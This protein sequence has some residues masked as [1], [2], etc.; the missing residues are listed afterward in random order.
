MNPQAPAVTPVPG[1][2]EAARRLSALFGTVEGRAQEIASRLRSIESG[3]GP[4][5]WAGQAADGFS[6]LL[7]ETG[8]DLTTLAASYGKASQA[9]ATYATEL[10]AAQDAARAAQAEATTAT[11]A[12]DR[13]STDQT[14]ARSDADRHAVEAADAQARMD[15]VGA[16]AAEQRRTDAVGRENAARGAADQAEQALRAAQQ[17]ADE[18]AGR[19]D[20]AAAKCIRELQD[21]SRAGIETRNI[22]QPVAAGGPLQIMTIATTLDPSTAAADA[23]LLR[24][25]V[26]DPKVADAMVDRAT[27]RLQEI[28]AQVEA[29]QPMTVQQQEYVRQS[30]ETAG[31]GTIAAL[32]V[33]VP[34]GIKDGAKRARTAVATT[35]SAYTDPNRREVNDDD[36]PMPEALRILLEDPFAPLYDLP[37][38]GPSQA[39]SDRV[40]QYEA[41]S[42]LLEESA[43]PV[44]TAFG[45]AAGR[46]ALEISQA[47]VELRNA[48]S[49]YAYG[50]DPV[51]MGAIENAA[52]NAADV[53]TAVSRNLDAAQGL[54]EDP[55][56]RRGLLLTQHIDETGAV[57][58]LDRATARIAP[59]RVDAD[60][61]AK[62]A[63]DLFLDLAQ[64]P[65]GWREGIA[66]GSKISHEIALTAAEHVDAFIRYAGGSAVRPSDEIDGQFLSKLEL[67]PRDAADLLTF[68]AAGRRPG[69]PDEDLIALHAAAQAYTRHHVM[70]AIE[71]GADPSTAL[72]EAGT[73]A[74]AVNTADFRSAV[75]AYESE[76]AAWSAVYD[77]AS[78]VAGIP[79]GRAVEFAA[80]AAPGWVGDALSAV[81]DNAVAGFQPAA[82]AGS[83]GQSALEAIE[84]RQ[85]LDINH[86]IVSAYQEAGA[87][88]ADTPN[89]DAITDHTGQ[90]SALDS[91]RGDQ[92]DPDVIE[93]EPGSQTALDEIA[94]HGP[95]GGNPKDW[96][97]A[98]DEYREAARL[99]YVAV[100]HANPAPRAP[101]DSAVVDSARHSDRY[102]QAIPWPLAVR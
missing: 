18:A 37:A 79:L 7:A 20:A 42:Q 1:D 97:D 88:P 87:L 3:V 28:A 90:V 55:N 25:G 62:I 61:N 10:A 36:T 63:H 27:A 26:A 40:A 11:E 46:R 101:L 2:P 16:Q 66:K 30:V 76:D 14:A 6:T 57:A 13:A 70:Q 96:Q 38:T 89:L 84:G 39:L 64:D 43:V 33:L 71:D 32:A 8:P 80:G 95:A 29:G 47:A 54:V 93:D 49:V 5:M 50:N 68:V 44:G 83:E 15:A 53:M 74:K 58:L 19:R 69:E 81:V 31:P 34:F 51:V 17:K 65:Y 35:L 23:E 92:S 56:F 86:L 12:R 48:S 60:Q 78:N 41:M 22:A 72:T 4:Q 21:A 24:A 75:Q 52:R 85:R 73:I 102:G 100:D 9:L 91:F 59:T 99:G 94:R 82:T 77:N 45:E 67:G 98:L